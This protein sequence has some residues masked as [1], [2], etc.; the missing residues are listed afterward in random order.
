MTQTFTF[1][2]L[3]ESV[4]ELSAMPEAN[5]SSPYAIAAVT[6][7]ILCNY[8]KNVQATLDML[9]YIK[10]PRPLTPY[11]KQFL[12][13]RLAGKGY[14]PFSF[15]AGSSP[16]NNY[17]PSYPYTVTVYDGPYSFNEEGYA[18]L[19]I[20]SSGA[21]SAR[22]ITLRAKGGTQWCLWE[23]FL[24]ADIRIPAADDPWA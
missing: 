13:D 12:R 18:K 10:G 24:L 6:V 22:P 4:A 8:E 16:Q 17:K 9:D 3:P 1:T 5:G 14:K 23:Q 21:D 15:F 11:E 7:A 20:Q 2:K 19:S